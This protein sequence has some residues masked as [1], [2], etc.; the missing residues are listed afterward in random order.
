MALGL[1][2][3]SAPSAVRGKFYSQ[4]ARTHSITSPVPGGMILA[5]NLIFMLEVEMKKASWAPFERQ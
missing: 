4:P 3:F 5:G 1:G 2:I